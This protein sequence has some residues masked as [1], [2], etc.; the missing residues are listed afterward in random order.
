MLPLLHTCTEKLLLSSRS[1]PHLSSNC[2]FGARASK[3]C[4]LHL[5]EKLRPFSRSCQS[6]CV[7]VCSTAVLKSC[8]F[9][10]RAAKVCSLSTPVLKRGDFRASH[11]CAGK[12]QLFSWSCQSVLPF[13]TSCDSQAR[14]AHTC[15]LNCDFRARAAKARFRQLCLKVATFQLA[16]PKSLF[17]TCAENW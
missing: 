2:D 11:T 14:A 3:A 12:L 13:Y 10:A 7:C 5:C 17:Y 9:R 4:F 1:C 6:V 8:D 15:P 16:L